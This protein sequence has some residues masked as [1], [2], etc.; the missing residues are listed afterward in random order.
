MSDRYCSC[1][2]FELLKSNILFVVMNKKSHYEASLKHLFVQCVPL[3]SL[4]VFQ[5]SKLK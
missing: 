2:Q 5:F 3:D 1:D 4:I